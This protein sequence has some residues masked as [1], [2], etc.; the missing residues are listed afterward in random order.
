MQPGLTTGAKPIL[1]DRFATQATNVP[2]KVI[3]LIRIINASAQATK[4]MPRKSVPTPLTKCK[5][6][7]AFRTGLLFTRVRC[8][9]FSISFSQNS[10]LLSPRGLFVS[11]IDH[12]EPSISLQYLAPSPIST[13]DFEPLFLPNKSQIFPPTAKPGTSILHSY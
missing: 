10:K 13:A 8:L 12:Q 1:T 4:P 11:S 3:N 5:C 6:H 2:P 9:D 7:K